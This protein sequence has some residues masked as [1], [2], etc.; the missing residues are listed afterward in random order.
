MS[1]ESVNQQ[2]ELESQLNATRLQLSAYAHDFKAVL[3][4]ERDKSRALAEANRQLQKYARDVRQAFDAER[5]QREQLKASYQDCVRRLV[6]ASRYKDEETGAHIERLSHYAKVIALDLKWTDA[7]IE[8]LFQA[9]PMHDVGKIAVPDA[10]LHKPGKLNDEEWQ[11]VKKHPAYG[12]SLLKGSASPL[13]ALA[14]QIALAHHERWDGSGYPRGITGEKIPRA[15][16]IVML[17]DQYDALRSKRA[18]KPAMTHAQAAK[19]ILEGDGRTMPQHFDPEI[20]ESFC[21]TQSQLAEVYDR[22]VD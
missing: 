11:V 15:A 1:P 21:R 19:V 16:R 17:V 20:L 22:F 14:H 9:T 2:S 12:A 4:A 8:V 13:L 7:A 5:K 18:Y 10:I 3:Q 6:S